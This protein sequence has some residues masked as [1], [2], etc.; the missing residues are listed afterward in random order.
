[1]T[2]SAKVW[3]SLKP[4][5]LPTDEGRQEREVDSTGGAGP[6]VIRIYLIRRQRS[7]VPQSLD[8]RRL[9]PKRQIVPP[10]WLLVA[11]TGKTCMSPL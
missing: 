2:R 5:A 10:T 3:S 6:G 8:C 7:R 11:T 9:E 1:M 4:K